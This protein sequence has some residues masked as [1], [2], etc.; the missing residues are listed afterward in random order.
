MRQRFVQRLGEGAGQP[1]EHL[2]F[3][4]TGKIRAGPARGQEELRNAGVA[5]VGHVGRDY[6]K[7]FAR[8]ATG[9]A[10]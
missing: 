9:F 2:A 3:H 5:L 4:A 8:C 6:G 10:D 1:G 7:G